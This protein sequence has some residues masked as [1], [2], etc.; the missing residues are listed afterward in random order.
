MQN[1]YSSLD[2]DERDAFNEIIVY[3]EHTKRCTQ[4]CLCVY[5]DL[6]HQ[7]IEKCTFFELASEV[8]LTH[9]LFDS[10]VIL[11][12]K[13]AQFKERYSLR[14]NPIIT[15]TTE[16]IKIWEK[17]YIEDSDLKRELSKR[18]LY[19][20]LSAGQFELNEFYNDNINKIVA[21]TNYLKVLTAES[22][23]D[24]KNMLD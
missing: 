6:I 21:K 9:K 17:F 8:E 14:E 18:Y 20:K 23:N 19:F 16:K 1:F 7:V 3:F 24:F 15:N 12:K 5:S 2:S 4:S 10:Q 11:V 22:L 13:A